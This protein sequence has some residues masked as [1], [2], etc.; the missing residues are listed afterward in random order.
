M[1]DS[2]DKFTDISKIMYQS[3]EDIKAN[4]VI[5]IFKEK[6]E[7][8]TKSFEKTYQEKL[9]EKTKEM[10]KDLTEK[11]DEKLQKIEDKHNE[12]HTK[13]WIVITGLVILCF[14]IICWSIKYYINFIDNKINNNKYFC[15]KIVDEKI[16][17]IT[18]KK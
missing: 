9:E 2:D 1:P 12:T 10:E 16:N 3:A 11:F 4:E 6:I 5:K 7:Q 8:I 18:L 14:N 15:E 13:S 17:N